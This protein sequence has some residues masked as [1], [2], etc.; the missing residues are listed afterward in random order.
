MVFCGS[1]VGG[2]AWIC[3]YDGDFVYYGCSN[4]VLKYS[5]DE[6]SVVESNN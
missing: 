3:A 6:K 1:N 2:F 4:V 5:L